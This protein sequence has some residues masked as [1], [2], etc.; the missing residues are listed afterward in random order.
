MATIMANA[1]IFLKNII[2]VEFSK[3]VQFELA[4]NWQQVQTIIQLKSEHRS[5][6]HA[7]GSL[8]ALLD[9]GDRSSSFTSSSECNCDK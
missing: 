5:S 6:D 8:Y 1:S 3:V 4:R 9:S 2:V 7:A